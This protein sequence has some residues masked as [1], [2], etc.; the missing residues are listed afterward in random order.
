M[1]DLRPDTLE[2]ET[3]EVL[4]HEPLARYT[5]WRIGGPARYFA[6]AGSADMLQKLVQWANDR[7]LPIFI[8]GGG[9]NILI[10]DGGFRGLVIRNRAM[11]Q[12]IEARGDDVRLWIES[13]APTAGTARK[14]AAQGYGGLVWAEGLPG[15]IGGALYGN[16]GCY[17]SE[18]NANVI[19]V[20]VL[21]NGEVE[22]CL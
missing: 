4:E 7:T 11:Q 9:S 18:M 15:T 19:R 21:V 12:R 13:G 6:N 16:V 8:L 3:F 22:E 14:M 2:T 10:A 17:G 5:S 1:G 20:W